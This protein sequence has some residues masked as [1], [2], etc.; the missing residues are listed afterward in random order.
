MLGIEISLGAVSAVEERVSEAVKPAVAEAW[1]RV[2]EDS[3][4]HT[5]GTTWYQ[6]NVLC[7]LWTIATSVATVFKILANGQAPTLAPLFGKKLG[8]LVSDRATALNFW[9][10]EKRQICWAHLLRKAV[11]FSERDGPS[12]RVMRKGPRGRVC[13]F[14]RVVLR[15]TSC[16]VRRSCGVRAVQVA[17]SFPI[18]MRL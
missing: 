18:R 12:S 1:N 5:D 15:L 7:A 2:E 10:M 3:V 11:S 4:K 8:I 17:S 13:A 9:A 14:R 16:R 6:S